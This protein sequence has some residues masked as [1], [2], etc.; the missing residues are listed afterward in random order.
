LRKS[1]PTT[2]HFTVPGCT[3][4]EISVTEAGWT[5][6]ARLL[7][8]GQPAAQGARREQYLVPLD[9]GEQGIVT[10]RGSFFDPLPIIRY[11]G[12]PIPLAEEL[13]WY[14]WIWAGLPLLLV[15]TGDMLGMLTGLLTFSYN[16]RL[17]RSEDPRLSRPLARYGLI[18]AI[19]LAVG[20]ISVL[21]SLP[22]PKTPGR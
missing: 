4:H 1:S 20:V 22:L 12:Q 14:Q 21:L 17:F 5:S 9:D 16:I 11:Q 19:S 3:Q 13:K 8:D 15:F 2:Y 6:R 10:V 18:L 7:V